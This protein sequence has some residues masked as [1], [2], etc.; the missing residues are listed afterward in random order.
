MSCCMVL[1]ITVIWL[2]IYNDGLRIIEKFISLPWHCY[3][4]TWLYSLIKSFFYQKSISLSIKCSVQKPDFYLTRGILFRVV[5]HKCLRFLP[6]ITDSQSNL[7]LDSNVFRGVYCNCICLCM[8]AFV[9]LFF[10]CRLSLI[11]HYGSTTL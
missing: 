2:I 5:N 11:G 4:D 10:V 8:H 3:I 9:H 1:W 7:S 6:P